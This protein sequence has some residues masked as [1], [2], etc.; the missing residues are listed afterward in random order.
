MN[1]VVAIA[2]NRMR[3]ELEA[4]LHDDAEVQALLDEV[5]DRRIDPASAAGTILERAA[6]ARAR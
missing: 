6:A 4:S 2:A 3:L 5:V 1:E